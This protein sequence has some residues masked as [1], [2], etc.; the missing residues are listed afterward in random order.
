MSDK[1]ISKLIVTWIEHGRASQLIFFDWPTKYTSIWKRLKMC[2][3]LNTHTC[4]S[5]FRKI[6][7]N[8]ICLKGANSLEAMVEIKSLIQ[9]AGCLK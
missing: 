6:K 8:F 3:S 1:L 9:A 4:E 2:S 5:E 7:V